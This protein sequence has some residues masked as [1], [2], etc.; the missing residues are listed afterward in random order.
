MSLIEQSHRVRTKTRKE[1]TLTCLNKAC[2][3]T[4]TKPLKLLNLQD[5][6]KKP[7]NACPYCL[8]EI[9][10]IETESQDPQEKN[11]SENSFLEETPS[12]NQEKPSNCEH[13][14]GYMNEKDGKQ[15]IPEECLLCSQV[16]ECLK[17]KGSAK[18]KTY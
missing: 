15:Q 1:T 2:G 3:K 12:Q 6:S 18:G 16:I 5:N 4:I 9:T 11:V 10:V 7:Y 8:T 13:Y 17:E 14:F